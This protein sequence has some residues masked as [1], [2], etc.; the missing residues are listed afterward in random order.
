VRKITAGREWPFIAAVSSYARAIDSCGLGVRVIIFDCNGV[1]VDSEP[2]AAEVA[3]QE[4]TR[5][6]VPVTSEVIGKYFF[7]RRPTDIFAAIETATRRKLPQ[8][9]AFTV[10]AATLKRFRA[11]LRA[12]PHMAYALSWLRGPKCVASSSP[13]D[14]IRTSLETTD[15]ARFF[16]QNLFSANSVDVGKPAPDLFLL[17]A[18]RM[19]VKPSD[20]VVVEDSPSGVAAAIAAGMTPIGFVGGS[21]A[22]ADLGQ[23]LTTAGAG[24]IIADMRQLKSTVVALR[25]W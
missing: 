17:V 7:G 15:L 20:C 21:H 23:Q 5:A 16:G 2:I 4:L 14:R 19:R 12:M 3:A 24:A 13:M 25:G 22:V 8:H 10:A 18:K 9:F 11:E 1:L 6:G